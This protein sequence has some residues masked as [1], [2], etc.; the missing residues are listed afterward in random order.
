[1]HFGSF[2][3]QLLFNATHH[4]KAMS[5]SAIVRR[6]V[7]V[8]LGLDMVHNVYLIH[9]EWKKTSL[10]WAEKERAEV[11]GRV[12]AALR[13]IA[14]HCSR[15]DE[16]RWTNVVTS[17]FSGGG[18]TSTPH[19]QT[20][21]IGGQLH[22]GQG[23]LYDWL[24]GEE[25]TENPSTEPHAC[26]YAATAAPPVP[27]TDEAHRSSSP[28]ASVVDSWRWLTEGLAG[29]AVKN[30]ASKQA[31]VPEKPQLKPGQPMNDARPCDAVGGGQERADNGIGQ[32]LPDPDTEAG[33]GVGNLEFASHGWS[34][35][36]VPPISDTENASL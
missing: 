24:L 30:F 19:L 27:P 36:Q 21:D 1:M 23:S 20:E 26:E 6:A 5:T 9:C 18:A 22:D 2:L 33:G 34:A 11:E 31:E 12:V 3:R 13:R 17:L 15:K 16:E 29:M 35:C 7:P 8:A 10:R 4:W 14:G 25:A 28:Q 32:L